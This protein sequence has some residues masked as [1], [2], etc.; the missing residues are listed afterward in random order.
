VTEEPPQA[1]AQAIV[2]ADGWRRAGLRAEVS[3][4]IQRWSSSSAGAYRDA[5]ASKL[6][7]Q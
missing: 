4:S 5:G 2:I 6:K 7:L 1:F 3:A